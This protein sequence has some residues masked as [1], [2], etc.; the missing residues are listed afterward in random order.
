M[1]NRKRTTSLR[2]EQTEA[3]RSALLEAARVSFAEHGY[4]GT[5]LDDVARAARTTKGAVY[6]HFADK[7]ALFRTVYDQLASELV[8]QIV[9]E[10]GILSENVRSSKAA[11]GASVK[12]ALRASLRAAAGGPQRRILYQDGPMVLG[13]TECRAIDSKYSLGLLEQLVLWRGDPTLVKAVGASTLGRLLL[14]T[15]IEAGQI[16]GAAD[17]PDAEVKR[18]ERA[19]QVLID[20]IELK[21]ERPAKKSR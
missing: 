21:R 1:S 8:A 15:I 19:L 6:H 11:A 10:S 18:L 7:R 20:A 5:S 3:T 12:R 16:I 9:A 13:G 14:A 17:E 4:E 2:A